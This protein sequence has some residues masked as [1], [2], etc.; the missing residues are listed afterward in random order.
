[1]DKI[2]LNCKEKIDELFS[3]YKSDSYMFQR[4]Q[5]HVLNILPTALENE[6]KTHTDRVI[7]NKFLLN[8][9][10]IFIQ[11]FLSKHQYYYLPNNCCFYYYDGKT[12]SEITEDDIQHELL[13]SISK[14]KTLMQWKHKTK[15]NIIK[16]IKDRNLFS[17]TPESETIQSV[18]NVLYPAFFSNKQEAKYFLT[19]IG[20][21]ILKKNSELIFLIKSKT[22]K[23]F[24]ELDNTAYYN[25]GVSNIT[26]NLISKYH[27]NYEYE[28]CRL[29]K[30]SDNVSLDIWRDILKKQGLN[31]LC[32]A[33]HYSNRYGN[34]D[35]FILSHVNEELRNY[36]FYLKK[37]TQ[38]DILKH[39]CDYAI[40]KSSP[41]TASLALNW[42]N[43]HYLWKLFIS[44]YSYPNM[45]YS[46]SLKNLL[47]DEYCYDEEKDAFLNITSK[48]L[49]LTSDFILFWDKT[50]TSVDEGN[51]CEEFEIDEICS[52]F[53]KWSPSEESVSYSGVNRT[54]GESDA[55]KI[56][57]HFYPNVEIVENKFILNIRCSMWNKA[58]D[59]QTALN[60]FKCHKF[61]EKSESSLISLDD[62]YKFYCGKNKARVVSKHYFEKYA[63]TFI[64]T[65]ILFDKFISNDW[66][67][68]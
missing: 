27:E 1:M 52:L 53:K 26:N 22:K 38:K 2:F 57:S 18:L 10:Q 7:R 65:H 12:Y 55:L 20:D 47:K 46:N 34:S 31:I 5:Y 36:T 3:K 59:I 42:K 33:A 30:I 23:F 25:I 51:L 35:S 54:I 17:S 37:S 67:E 40:E 63:S 29:L 50:I 6:A 19:V 62:A 61:E 66:F 44:H 11:V 43:M 14:D 4:F 16:Q 24:S 8:E 15:V 64:A 28:K 32:V 68:A 21:N 60:E 48:Y 13:T 49:P 58:M 9:Q 45:I 39:F 41:T 56:I